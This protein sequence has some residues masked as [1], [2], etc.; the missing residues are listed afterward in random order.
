MNQTVYG[1]FPSSDEVIQAIRLLKQKGYRAEDITLI[2]NKKESLD[3][4]DDYA[5]DNVN[6]LTNEEPTFMEKV[7][8]FFKAESTSVG[9]SDAEVTYYAEEIEQGNI[10]VLVGS[11]VSSSFD[12]EDS[13]QLDEDDNPIMKENY[14]KNRINTDYL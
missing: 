8:H 9:M 13:I 4:T 10:L 7:S 3:F 6:T 14:Y 5:S 1:I 12:A 2:A 11:S